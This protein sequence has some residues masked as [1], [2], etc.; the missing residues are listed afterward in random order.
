MLQLLLLRPLYPIL[1]LLYLDVIE[2]EVLLL[3]W[4]GIIPSALAVVGGL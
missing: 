1:Q 4:F 2:L 3:G